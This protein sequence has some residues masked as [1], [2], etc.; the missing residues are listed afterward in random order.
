MTVRETSYKHIERVPGVV[1]GD[2]VIKGTRVPVWSIVIHQ[3]LYG[4]IADIERA[5]PRVSRAAAEEALAYYEAHREEID[6]IIAENEAI[7]NSPCPDE[8]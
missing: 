1:G 5:Y 6:A 3:Q 2:P 4:T 7:A 8:A